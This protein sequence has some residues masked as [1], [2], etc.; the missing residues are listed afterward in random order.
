MTLREYFK[1]F[2]RWMFRSRV[3][4]SQTGEDLIASFYLGGIKK[5]FYVDIGTNDPVYLN[6]TYYF[7]KKGWSGVC[8]EPNRDRCQLIRL[9]RIRDVVV[10]AGVSLQ[11]GQMSYYLFYPDTIST[12]SND[13]AEEFRKLGHKLERTLI[14]PT[15]P[16][17]D[18]LEAQVQG[19]AIDLMS[20][21]TEG[22]DLEV[23]K[24]NN[25]D[26]FRPKVIIVEIAEYRRDRLV[27]THQQFDEFLASKNYVK[28]ADTYINGIYMEREYALETH[29]I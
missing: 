11:A 20:I 9:R 10:N 21:D 18:I 29:I 1:T 25:W 26:K 14:I 19:R 7:Y 27:R 5:G 22:W 8:V 12:F 6:N 16:L 2:Y 3:S 13:E 17:R 15:F 28:I 23:L 4:Y 24:S